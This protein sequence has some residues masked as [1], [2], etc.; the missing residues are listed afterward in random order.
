[1][2]V[3]DWGIHLGIYISD[4]SWEFAAAEHVSGVSCTELIEADWVR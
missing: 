4:A 3:D 2:T 1:M